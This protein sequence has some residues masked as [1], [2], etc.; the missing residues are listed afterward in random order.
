MWR[1]QVFPI[2]TERIDVG[3][4][5]TSVILNSLGSQ[6]LELE[7]GD[8][9]AVSSKVLS[10]SQGRVVRLSGVEASEEAGRL[11]EAHSL[12]PE[13]V[14]LV[15]REA[16]EVY[17]GVHG[18]LLTLKDGV[19]TANAGVDHKNAPPGHA[20]LWPRNPWMEAERIRREILRRTGRRIGVIIVDSHL[21]PLRMGTRGLALAV[22]GFRP[23]ADLRG[24]TDLYG[25]RIRITRHSIADDLASTAHLVMGEADEGTPAAL[26]RGAPITL[27]EDVNPSE[28]LI[29]CDECIYVK[30]LKGS[31]P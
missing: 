16:D 31:R 7:D 9:L 3:C 28:T 6:N 22:A 30:G 21:S 2:K 12:E 23:V 1:L 10:T 14:E 26:I 19:L 17:G 15:L 25:R 5:L 29:S 4:D 24:R 11:A 13:F 8:V 27:T 18:A 20:A